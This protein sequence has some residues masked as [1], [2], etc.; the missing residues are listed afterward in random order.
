M[1]G[2]SHKW[3]Y[4]F[5]QLPDA[6]AVRPHPAARSAQ[7]ALFRCAGPP[8]KVNLLF[9]FCWQSNRTAWHGSLSNWRRSHSIL[10]A[11]LTSCVCIGQ[12]LS[13]M[14]W[15]NF[16]GASSWTGVDSMSWRSW[17]RWFRREIR[18]GFPQRRFIPCPN[19][20]WYGQ[21]KL[22][23][24]QLKLPGWRLFS[25]N[26]VYFEYIIFFPLPFFQLS[27]KVF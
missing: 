11:A 4:W 12:T 7:W 26:R 13:N 1:V 27:Q 15:K 9:Q 10:G 24:T 16:P 3:L 18:H 20:T 6:G 5:L 25:V 2:T 23:M 22:T 8:K 21:E 19:P 14:L 17:L